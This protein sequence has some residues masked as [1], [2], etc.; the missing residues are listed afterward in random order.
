M[1]KLCGKWL[2]SLARKKGGFG[3][4]EVLIS[5]V[6][7]GFLYM[8]VLNLQGG[9]HEA[10]LRI[11]SRD[12]ATDVAKDVIDSLKSQ[13][14]ASLADD[15]LYSC[16]EGCLQLAK[17]DA[18]GLK[19]PDTLRYSR[20]WKGQPGVIDHEMKVDYKAVVMVSPDADFM[21]TNTSYLKGVDSVK[22]VYAKRVDVTVSWRFKGSVQSI[23]VSG[24]IK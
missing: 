16:G 13:G 17:K 20:T 12:G 24:V 9:N 21:T 19:A 1:V 3:I 2:G 7:L 18:A 6:V 15:Q 23:T 5:A 14:I 10:L 8:A 4:T 11:R 22:H